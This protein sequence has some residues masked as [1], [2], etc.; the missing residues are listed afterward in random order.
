MNDF[1]LLIPFGPGLVHVESAYLH[2]K[3]M[4]KE[5]GQFDNT[6]IGICTYS[7]GIPML[8]APFTNRGLA[9]PA[10]VVGVLWL[11]TVHR[12]G[13]GCLTHRVGLLYK[14]DLRSVQ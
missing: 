10:G 4:Y 12:L 2:T 13:L 1:P 7:G 8:F 6:E 3:Q 5:Y 11:T 9:W 14:S